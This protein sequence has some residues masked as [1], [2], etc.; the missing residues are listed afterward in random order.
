MSKTVK[1]Y[2]NVAIS[3]SLMLF[4]RYIPAPEPMTQLGMTVIGIFAGA[5]YGWCT[6]NMIWPSIAALII[7]GFTG[8]VEVSGSWGKVMGNMTVGIC[9]WL[10]VSVGL[11][12]NTGLIDYI[13]NWS[14]TRKFTQGKP[15]TLV[16]V[17]FVCCLA[18]ASVLAE[19]A[20]TLAFWALVWSI[21]E[22]VGYEKGSRTGTWMTFTVALIVGFG[23]YLLPFK[24]AVF[25]NFGFLAAGSNGAFDGS[26]SYG[27]WTAFTL[28]IVTVM[29]IVYLLIS[30]YIIKV[31]LSKFESYVP[32]PETAVEP[33]NKKQKVSLILFAALFLL[34][35]V[36]S[37]LPKTWAI[38]KFLNTFGTVGVAMLIVCITTCIR[39]DGEPLL[40]FADMVGNNVIWN[41]ILMFGTALTLC[42]CIN[43]P[44]AGVSAWLNAQMAPVFAHVSPYVFLV[45]YLLLAIII[46]NVINNAVVGAVLIPISFTLSVSMG[47]NPVAV[48]ACMIMFTDFGVMLPSASPTGALIHNSG[49]WIN[50][51]EKYKYCLLSIV[52]YILTSLLVGWPVANML[53]PFSM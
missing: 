49:G 47:L 1:W 23:G 30:K 35:M 29:M 53:F 25:S 32:D 42:A 44:A 33:L 5:I 15:W 4:F 20:V 26:Y 52:L 41:I 18:C 51:N 40:D 37:F 17:I 6:T 46:T 45:A 8:Q 11:L 7:F 39:V 14:V 10:M 16:L 19:V 38:A 9:F 50:D 48:C 22:K 21:C 28:S 2:I 12:K 24:M 43:S 36:P 3:L 13:A 31:D 34:L 27:A